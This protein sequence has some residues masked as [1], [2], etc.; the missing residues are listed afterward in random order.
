MIEIRKS[1][2]ECSITLSI[3][4]KEL[5]FNDTPTE[6]N[7][8]TFCEDVFNAYTL[9]ITQALKDRKKACVTNLMNHSNSIVIANEEF[10]TYKRKSGGTHTFSFNAYETITVLIKKIQSCSLKALS[11]YEL[12]QI[13]KALYWINKEDIDEYT[14]QDLIDVIEY[15][16]STKNEKTSNNRL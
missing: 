7:Y 12:I 2:K 11:K 14:F 6:A 15:Y 9:L 5:S 1:T 8:K 4:F 10:I 16:K 13:S 3:P